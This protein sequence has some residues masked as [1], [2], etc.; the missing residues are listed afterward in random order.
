MELVSVN[1]NSFKLS[2]RSKDSRMDRKTTRVTWEIE[3][4]RKIA[5]WRQK[6]N[7]TKVLV[8]SQFVVDAKFTLLLLGNLV[9]LY[10]M[11]R[12]VNDT[13]VVRKFV[14]R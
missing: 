8:H 1:L 14:S 7:E 2:R 5:M 12:A 9:N 6:L 11:L 10:V 3:A 4:A 13:T